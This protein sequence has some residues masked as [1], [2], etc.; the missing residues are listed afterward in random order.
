MLG[1]PRVQ[2]LLHD[3]SDSILGPSSNAGWYFAYLPPFFL[4]LNIGIGGMYLVRPGR[5]LAVHASSIATRSALV[6]V[7]TCHFPQIDTTFDGLWTVMCSVSS[8]LYMPSG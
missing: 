7:P 8:I 6:M 1:H 3:L 5:I 2:Q 4:S